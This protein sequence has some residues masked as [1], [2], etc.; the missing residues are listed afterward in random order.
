ML[1]RLHFV[2]AGFELTTLVDQ[3]WVN[4]DAE[5]G[6]AIEDPIL[7]RLNKYSYSVM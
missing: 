7:I 3:P 5:K 4:Y 6:G 2:W 1:Y